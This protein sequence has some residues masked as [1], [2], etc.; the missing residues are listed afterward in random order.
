MSNSP[1]ELQLSSFD[2]NT[3]TGWEG[4]LDIPNFEL[5]ETDSQYDDASVSL[6]DEAALQNKE[7]TEELDSSNIEHAELHRG[8]HLDPSRTV[9]DVAKVLEEHELFKDEPI[10]LPWDQQYSQSDIFPGVRVHVVNSIEDEEENFSPDTLEDED[11]KVHETVTM[12]KDSLGDKLGV[13]WDRL[14]WGRKR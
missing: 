13:F 7:T 5:E 9:E 14:V 4:A 11:P 12:N 2:V 3:N 8:K 6:F 10:A 1:A